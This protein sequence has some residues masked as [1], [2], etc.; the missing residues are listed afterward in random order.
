MAV[1]KLPGAFEPELLLSG[2]NY[3]LIAGNGWANLFHFDYHAKTTLPVL[4][5]ARK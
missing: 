2:R 3:I 1:Y 4:Q 5:T